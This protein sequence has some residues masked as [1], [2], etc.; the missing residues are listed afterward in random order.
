MRLGSLSSVLGPLLFCSLLSSES[1]ATLKK[2]ELLRTKAE[3]E[4]WKQTG[5]YAEVEELCQTFPTQFSGRVRC[6]EFG[7][8]PEGRPMLALIAADKAALQPE[9]LSPRSRPVVFIQGGIHAGEIDGKDAGFIFLRELLLGQR[10][11]GVLEKVTL[12]FVPVF[13][14]DGHER[15]GPNNRPNQ[16]GPS[17]MGWRTTAQ[18]YNLNRDYLKADAPEMQAMLELL[19]RWDPLL[20]IDLHVTDGAQFQHDIAVMIETHEAAPAALK[21]AGLALRERTMQSLS[22]AG[23]LPLW[24]YPSFDKDDEPASGISIRP[25]SARFSNGYWALRNRLGVLVE[26][27]SWRN[28]QHRIRATLASLEALVAAAAEEGPRWQVA[29]READLESS[30]LGGRTVILRYKNK[31]KAE[32][33]PFRGY[34]YTRRP[35]EVSGQLM[36]VYDPSKPEI[37]NL[38]LRLEIEAELSLKAP[39]AGYLIP[40]AYR[41]LLL[42]R[43]KAHQLQ[44]TNLKASAWNQK[45]FPASVYRISEVTLEAKSYEKRQRASYK[46]SW[47][48]SEELVKDGSIW[49]PIEQKGARLIMQLFEPESEDSLLAW[50]FFNEIFERKEYMEPY[51]AET[52]A[53]EMLKDPAIK[54]AFESKIAEEPDFAKS[55]EQRLDFFYQRHASFDSQLNRY[56]ILRFERKPSE[57]N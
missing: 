1:F 2:Q 13:N 49:L 35:S 27:H 15:F 51:V 28:Y 30:R 16:I 7:R 3:R 47:Q 20:Y 38:P 14:V 11:K 39:R 29:A 36:T 45:K 43:L 46:G 57:W 50:G 26:A 18:N 48:A 12:V 31:H 33:F 24:F 32:N 41:E 10:L 56:P 44:F 55:P 54:A 52:V 4:G 19:G 40:P 17:E 8:T 6:E 21:K 37:W 53:R 22:A 42:P 34:A 5:R 23:H 9:P 25:Q